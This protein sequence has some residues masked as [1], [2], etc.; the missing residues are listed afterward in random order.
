MLGGVRRVVV[1]GEGA[2]KGEGGVGGDRFQKVFPEAELVNL[3]GCTEVSG[4][5][6]SFLVTPPSSLSLPSPSS[7]LPIGS[8]LPNC[9]L[10][11]VDPL[12][13]LPL[14]PG[15]PGKILVGGPFVAPFYVEN[16]SKKTSIASCFP[17]S[18]GRGK[19]MGRRSETVGSDGKKISKFSEKWSLCFGIS[20]NSEDWGFFDTGDRGIMI[21]NDPIFS[22]LEREGSVWKVGGRRVS[23]AEIERGFL[24]GMAEEVVVVCVTGAEGGGE[25]TNK[26]VGVVLGEENG[27]TEGLDLCSPSRVEQLKKCGG[28]LLPWM[29]PDIFFVTSKWPRT[30]TSKLDR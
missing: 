29:V 10:L 21:K 5:V 17:F 11:L 26:L 28:T 14:P 27:E 16:G 8:P 3:Y 7:F 2:R 24:E 9:S 30:S 13:S 12:F 19:E 18:G 4:D 20:F 22:F 1:S 23:G 25:E 6:T 15:L